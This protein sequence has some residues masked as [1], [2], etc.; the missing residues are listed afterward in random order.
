MCKENFISNYKNFVLCVKKNIN[1]F[2]E[3]NDL[4]LDL[5]SAFEEKLKLNTYETHDL[6]GYF[7]IFLQCQN[8][9]LKVFFKTYLK[10]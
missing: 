9:Q 2:I 6:N 1:F 8:Y 5:Q 10:L 4:Y 3:I 7:S